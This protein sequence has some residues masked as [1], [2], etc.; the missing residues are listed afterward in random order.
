MLVRPIP[1]L[2][3]LVF[4]CVAL[5]ISPLGC[6][7][8]PPTGGP[9]IYRGVLVGNSVGIVDV[10]VVE[11][12]S[13]P[14]PATGAIDFGSIVDSLSGTLDR[15]SASISLSSADGYQL[16][17]VSRPTYIFGS[18]NQGSL[19]AGTFALF[20]EASDSSPIRFLCGSYIDSGTTTPTQYPFAVT[21]TSSGLAF[22]VT[23]GFSWFGALAA[24]GTLS[25]QSGGGLF[26]GNTNADAGNQWGTGVDN[27]GNGD[28]GTWTVA[29]CRAGAADGGVDRG[30]DGGPDAGAKWAADGE[31]D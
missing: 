6:A 28:Y 9:G 22:C 16:D 8:K 18:Y 13:G 20:L 19:D 17:G 15:S 23:P 25:C 24:D 4:A 27:S 3:G 21:A 29:P 11:A 2:R 12:A 14:L 1:T 26:S 7:N 30:L 5:A 10:T 31:V